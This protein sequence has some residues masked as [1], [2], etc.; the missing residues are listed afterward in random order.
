MFKDTALQQVVARAVTAGRAA[1]RGNLAPLEDVLRQATRSGVLSQA[2]APV[3][4]QRIGQS[5]RGAWQLSLAVVR[6]SAFEKL[7]SS[8]Q[9]WM[10]VERGCPCEVSAAA[11]RPWLRR[12]FVK[13]NLHVVSQSQS[14]PL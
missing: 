10:V 3:I 14:K 11:C 5:G 2:T 6:T 1:E 8:D 9:L 13:S 4:V 12:V 7:K